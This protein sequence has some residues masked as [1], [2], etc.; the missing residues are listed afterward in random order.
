MIK[1]TIL[2]FLWWILLILSGCTYNTVPENMDQTITG[3]ENNT[4]LTGED[5]QTPLVDNI[6]GENGEY[7]LFFDENNISKNFTLYHDAR[8]Q[9]NIYFI[10]DGFKKIT[11]DIVLPETDTW[12]NLRLSMITM[13]DGTTDGPFGLHT[14]Y[15]LTQNGGYQLRIGENMMAWEPRTGNA[16]VT[17]SVSK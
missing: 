3:D 7:T 16:Q 13:P 10:N 12:T 9:N 2:S 14:E 6:S 4:V 5:I 17:I 8:Q 1:T 11:I 15:N